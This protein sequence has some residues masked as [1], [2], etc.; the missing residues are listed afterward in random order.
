MNIFTFSQSLVWIAGNITY[1]FIMPIILWYFYNLINNDNYNKIYNC[2]F[3][4]INLFG[5]MFVE[6]MGLVLIT[7]NILVLIYKYVKNKKVDTKIIFY[8]ILSILSTLIMLLSPGSRFRSNM[9]NTEFNELNIIQKVIY[10]VPNFVYYTFIVNYFMLGLIS[11]CNY[12]I[13]KNKI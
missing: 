7:G 12:L 11:Y 6:H 8:L 13:I 3:L 5:T 4:L 1:F 10:N 2:L 9:G